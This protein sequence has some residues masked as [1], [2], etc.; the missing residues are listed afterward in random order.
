MWL[1]GSPVPPLCSS[2]PFLL[3]IFRKPAKKEQK[4]QLEVLVNVLRRIPTFFSVSIPFPTDFPARFDQ[5]VMFF[6]PEALSHPLLRYSKNPSIP[7]PHCLPFP[8]LLLDLLFAE[9]PKA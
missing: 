5:N 1:S 7:V 8:E 4:L 2:F 3:I 6:F 9:P